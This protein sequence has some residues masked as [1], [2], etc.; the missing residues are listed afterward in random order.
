MHFYQRWGYVPAELAKYLRRVQPPPE[1]VRTYIR[2]APMF[3][4]R[5]RL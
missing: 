2:R 1:R 4:S 5:N 3:K